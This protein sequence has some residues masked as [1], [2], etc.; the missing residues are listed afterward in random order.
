LGGAARH[1]SSL[2][3]LAALNG[4]IRFGFP[5][6]PAAR[7]PRVQGLHSADCQRSAGQFDLRIR[8]RREHH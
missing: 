8:R 5:K 6:K 3:S 4:Q 7:G 1:V 2:A